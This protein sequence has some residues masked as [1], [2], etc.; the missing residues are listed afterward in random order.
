M[1]HGDRLA[2]GKIRAGERRLELR[3]AAR[4]PFCDDVP[5]AAARAGAD[6]DEMIARAHQRFVVLDDDHRVALLLQVAQ[7]GDEPLVVARVQADRR[8][9][10]QVQHADQ[11]GADARGQPHALPLAAAERVGRAVE[12]QILGADAVEKFKPADDFGDDRLGDRLLVGVERQAVER[13]RSPWSPRA[14]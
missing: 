3:D 4:R 6:V 5:A 9:I 11:P 13:T 14:P 8:L 2:A 1:R 10:E 12:R 7:R